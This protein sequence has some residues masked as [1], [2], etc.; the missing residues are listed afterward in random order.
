[1]HRR[2]RRIPFAAQVTL[3]TG[4]DVWS[5]ELLEIALK[6]AMVGTEAPLPLDIGSRCNL[7]IILP[8]TTISLDFQA[9]LKHCEENHYGFKFISE[10]LG[11]LTHLRKLLELN[12]GDAETTR[13]ELSAWLSD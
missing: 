4:Q 9:E 5:A 12:T 3:S 10:D 11:T 6:G 1:M 8:G 13:N 7:S 2:F